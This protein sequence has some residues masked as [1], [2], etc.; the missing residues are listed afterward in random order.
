VAGIRKNLA[1]AVR[2]LATRT[3]VEQLKKQ[4]VKQV[5]VVGLDRIV[6][7]IDEAVHRTLRDKLLVG[8]RAAI[9]D[10]TREEFMRLLRSNEELQARHQRD[11]EEVNSLRLELQKL[12]QELESRIEAAQLEQRSSWE[13]E[14]ERI[15]ET[16]R[17]VVST[18]LREGRD[19]ARL[20][21][22]VLEV[23]MGLVSEERRTT[24]EA[25]AQG[26]RRALHRAWT[27][28]RRGLRVGEQRCARDGAV[29]RR[30]PEGRRQQEAAEEGRAVR[31]GGAREAPLAA[32]QA[33][34]EGRAQVHRRPDGCARPIEIARRGPDRRG[35]PDGQAAQGRTRLRVIG[36]PAQASIK[37]K[38]AI[39]ERGARLTST[40]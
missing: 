24:L 28:A 17:S 30:L 5:S 23:V 15:A 8:E 12:E 13:S 40:P 7:L 4:G 33:A 9:A 21:Q 36:A 10:A 16:V 31:Q 2:K 38:E 11:A 27:S 35:D 6:A 26:P 14:D 20:E 22:R 18:A 25:K 3:S 37:N 29:R 34:R 32:M 19:P 39:L 1:D